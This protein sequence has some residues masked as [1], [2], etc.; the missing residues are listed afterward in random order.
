MPVKKKVGRRQ[1]GNGALWDIIS[2]I[3]KSDKLKRFL[4]PSSNV[5]TKELEKLAAGGRK[6]KK[7]TLRK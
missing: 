7:K 2:G 4:T 6:R 5:S 1:K 3:F